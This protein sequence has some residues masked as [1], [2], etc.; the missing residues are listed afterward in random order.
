ML[1]LRFW[2]KAT[3]DLSV[4]PQLTNLFFTQTISQHD[5]SNHA[6]KWRGVR[7]RRRAIRRA[8]DE[9]RARAETAESKEGVERRR[10][11]I[12]LRCRMIILARAGYPKAQQTST[13]IAHLVAFNEM[14]HQL[15][16]YLRRD[17]R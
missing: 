6:T 13:N 2:T 15:Y 8:Q 11:L 7:F 9:P 14:Q 4:S 5:P 16:N 1:I 12:T 3:Y 17:H 10:W